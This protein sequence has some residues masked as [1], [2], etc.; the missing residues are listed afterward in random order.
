[1]QQVV[2]NTRDY[3]IGLSLSREAIEL[4]LTTKGIDYEYSAFLGIDVFTINKCQRFYTQNIERDDPVLVSVVRQLG[5]K[6]NGCG[7]EFCNLKIVE[8]PDDVQWEIVADD[9][10]SECVAEV[11][12]VWR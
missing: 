10:G 9:D 7:I 3:N 4:F 2:I 1:M 12:R 5:D 8:I 11:H 6:A